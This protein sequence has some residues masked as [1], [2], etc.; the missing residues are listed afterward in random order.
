MSN[1]EIDKN[2]I[3]KTSKWVRFLF[4]A[5]YAFAIG[6]VVNISIG[7]AFIQF[8]FFLVTSKPNS[9]IANFNKHLIEFFN[10]SLAFI[11]F[12]TEEKPFPFK[13]EDNENTDDII[14]ADLEDVESTDSSEIPSDD[15]QE[16]RED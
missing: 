8:L 2:E 6:F 5:L 3:L 11:L 12:S 16:S 7:L 14:E 1:I 10:D 4:M 13:K 9:S 15:I